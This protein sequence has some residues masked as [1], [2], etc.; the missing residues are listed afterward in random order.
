MRLKKY[1]VESYGN[2]KAGDK[3]LYN[4]KKLT[5]KNV[6]SGLGHDKYIRVRFDGEKSDRDIKM[7]DF[8]K[9]QNKIKLLEGYTR[10]PKNQIPPAMIS[11]KHL[12]AGERNKVNKDIQKLLKPTYF[13]Q[14]PLDKLFKII[15][16]HNMIVL[17]E[18]MTEWS[19]FLMGGVKETEMVNFTL[20][21]KHDESGLKSF[22]TY[23]AVPNAMLV[24]TYYKMPASGN[25]EV[26]S[27]VS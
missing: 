16:K 19:G 21:W 7:T 1:L 23:M 5:I 17:Q 26:I 20:G 2:P 25:Y 12:K 14:I 3:V 22:K 13:K 10:M 15:E 8:F 9:P 18:D 6:G 4:N 27:Y 24:L 11:K